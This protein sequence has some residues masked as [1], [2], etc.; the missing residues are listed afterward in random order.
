MPSALLPACHAAAA[1]GV[2][3]VA[4]VYHKLRRGRFYRPN[5]AEAAALGRRSVQL[6][7]GEAA[8]VILKQ[9]SFMRASFSSGLKPGLHSP[10]AAS[11]LMSRWAHQ[12]RSWWRVRYACCMAAASFHFRRHMPLVHRLMLQ[13]VAL[14]ASTDVRQPGC[15]IASLMSPEAPA[16]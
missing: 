15:A 2:L 4:V 16:A 12:W 6:G 13:S 10:A 8:E 5:S 14:R 11:A 1:I 3:V 7:A 9:A